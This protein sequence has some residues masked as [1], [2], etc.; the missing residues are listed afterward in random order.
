MGS[1]AKGRLNLSYYYM[2]TET[3]CTVALN[4]YLQQTN[5]DV[6]LSYRAGIVREM[7]C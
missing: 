1:Y 4:V 6:K 5:T 3:F 7:L 2:L